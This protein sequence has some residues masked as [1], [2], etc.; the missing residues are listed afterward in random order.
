M[1]EKQEIRHVY[2]WGLEHQRLPLTSPC[3]VTTLHPSIPLYP[4][5]SRSSLT[6]GTSSQ[7]EF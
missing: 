6:L 1:P 5:P 7:G 2:S 3:Q 4:L